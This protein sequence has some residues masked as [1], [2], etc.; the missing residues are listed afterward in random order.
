[1]GKGTWFSASMVVTAC[2]L[3]APPAFAQKGFADNGRVV[4]GAERLTGVFVE[5]ISITQTTTFPD[6]A[7]GTTTT[8]SEAEA[9]TT[10]FALFGTTTGLL[11]AASTTVGGTSMAPR[12]AFDVFVASGFSLGGR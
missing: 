5:K 1:M 11:G 2:L 8:E 6:A 4:I 10:T 12:L 3:S 7:G 9:S